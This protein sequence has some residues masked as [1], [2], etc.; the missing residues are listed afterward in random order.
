[1][2]RRRFLGFEAT[3]RMTRCRCF[4]EDMGSK[5]V[6]QFD[7]A[8]V[9]E[10][11]LYGVNAACAPGA[12][13]NDIGVD[14]CTCSSGY[15]GVEEAGKLI[16]RIGVCA[17]AQT[18]RLHRRLFRSLY[19]PL[20]VV[21]RQMESLASSSCFLFVGPQLHVHG[22]RL[23]SWTW[24]VSFKFYSRFPTMTGTRMCWTTRVIPH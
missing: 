13:Y 16:C 2:L 11:L 4:E 20:P 3:I 17:V 14:S 19:L 7:D 23:A 12:C 8:H 10:C 6:F 21:F 18:H 15:E 24:K 9:H 22:V 1:M 5:V